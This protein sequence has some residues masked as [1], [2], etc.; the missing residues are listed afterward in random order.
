MV[1]DSSWRTRLCL[2]ISGEKTHEWT[3]FDKLK[4]SSGAPFNSDLNESPL[5]IRELRFRDAPP[6]AAVPSLRCPVE[7]G[8]HQQERD[9]T[10]NRVFQ[11]PHV[12]GADGDGRESDQGRDL[13]V[14]RKRQMDWELC[15]ARFSY[16]A[17]KRQ[18]GE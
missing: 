10:R 12:I 6:F 2:Q 5:C 4:A 14:R 16:S 15:D 18:V 9:E 7:D 3:W 17:A 13:R 8:N 11:A 1:A